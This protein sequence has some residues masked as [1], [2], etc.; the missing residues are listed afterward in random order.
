MKGR[1]IPYSDAEIKFLRKH[2]TTPRPELCKLFNA[3]FGRTV[4]SDNIKAKCTRM[5]LKTGRTGAFVKGFTPHNKGVKGW[6]PPGVERGWFKKGQEPAN[7]RPIGHER[8]CPKDGYI[9]IK[10]DEINPHTGFKGRFVLKHKHLWEAINGPVPDGHFLKCLDGNRSN[11]S[12]DNWECLPNGMKPRLVASRCGQDYDNA[13]V[14]IK[15]SIMLSAKV[16][17]KVYELNGGAA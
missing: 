7:L 14:E 13:P 17:Q 8:T 3:K 11:T 2:E 6:C 12:P 4:S 1:S 5:G 10:I 9:S 15:P 16:S